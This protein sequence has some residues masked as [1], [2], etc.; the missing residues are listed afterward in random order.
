MNKNLLIQLRKI[1]TYFLLFSGV[2][3]NL[4][5]LYV[6]AH[7]IF[8]IGYYTGE[9]IEWTYFILAM[10]AFVIGI[11][12]AINL[13]LSLI[14][15]T[16]T[17]KAKEV[18]LKSVLNS[19]EKKMI[20]YFVGLTLILLVVAVSFEFKDRAQ[21]EENFKSV[22]Q[23]LVKDNK[24]TF[25]KLFDYLSDSISIMKTKQVLDKMD[26]KSEEISSIDVFFRF[27]LKDS[28]EV[29]LISWRTYDSLLVNGNLEDLEVTLMEKEQSLILKMFEGSI[30]EPK[31]SRLPDGK[32]KGYYPL[33]EK[34]KVL[35]LRFN[36]P[37]NTLLI[38]N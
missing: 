26:G 9:F 8:E 30:K 4:W 23:R 24:T 10:M 28:I 38:G 14:L 37:Y 2:M 17:S 33:H 5:F 11:P 18:I 19:S 22:T 35:V 15:I 3:V 7:L 20:K 32:L 16:N 25:S 21:E 31:T 27:K 13:I 29:G 34:G 1:S 6:V 12:V 36:P